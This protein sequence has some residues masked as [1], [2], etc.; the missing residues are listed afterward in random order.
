MLAKLPKGVCLIAVVFT[1][2]FMENQNIQKD[3]EKVE[4]PNNPVIELKPKVDR[5]KKRLSPKQKKF[6]E[7][8]IET[9]NGGQSVIEAGYGVKGMD[10]AYVVA[11]DNLRKFKVQQ[12]LNEASVI[13][14]DTIVD[15]AVNAKSEEVKLK[16][17]RDI[18][19]RTG[20]KPKEE[21]EH[22]FKFLKDITVED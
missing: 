5:S 7:R 1:L 18:L 13:A 2:E 16:A 22:E 4:N 9:G 19:D 6:V 12:A 11:S 15:L 8:Y 20:F 21:I 17:S 14:K 3:Q 10:S